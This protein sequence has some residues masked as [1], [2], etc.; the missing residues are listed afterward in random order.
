MA[1]SG[2][3]IS[4]A[5]VRTTAMAIRNLNESLNNDLLE[6]QATMT[7]LKSSWQS[8]GCDAIQAKFSGVASKYFQNY[9]DVVDSYARFLEQAVAESYET[10]E[11]A[12]ES[13]ANAF[14]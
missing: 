13:N 2:I 8:D 6:I 9:H 5:E 1:A 7:N 4:T 14:N 3:K 11:T 12:I 10:T